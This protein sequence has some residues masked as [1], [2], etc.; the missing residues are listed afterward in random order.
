MAH[1]V[2][3]A[4]PSAQWLTS[5]A[6]TKH[7][8]S[9]QGWDTESHAELQTYIGHN[10]N[11]R[12]HPTRAVS[13]LCLSSFR[14]ETEPLVR[15]RTST[16]GPFKGN[17]TGTESCAGP[18]VHVQSMVS[19]E[20]TIIIVIISNNDKQHQQNCVK[21]IIEYEAILARYGICVCKQSA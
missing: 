6:A 16:A 21:M 5:V 13:P 12:Y 14:K 9:G 3:P 2:R 18:R 15:N 8:R 4:E 11:T 7:E 20:M 10:A 19:V 1:A 17:G